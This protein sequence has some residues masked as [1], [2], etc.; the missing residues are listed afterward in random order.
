MRDGYGLVISANRPSDVGVGSNP[1]SSSNVQ[2]TK[3]M[4]EEE[5]SVEKPKLWEQLVAPLQL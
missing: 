2:L 3:M 4:S 5:V 1:P